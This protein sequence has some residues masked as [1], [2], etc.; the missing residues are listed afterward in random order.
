MLGEGR[1]PLGPVHVVGGYFHLASPVEWSDFS[2][3]SSGIKKDG[4]RRPEVVAAVTNGSLRSLGEA[5]PSLPRLQGG[6]G[7]SCVRAAAQGCA[8]LSRSDRPLGP[9]CCL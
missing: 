6:R 3:G 7:L 2:P 9:C 8:R 1:I 4:F 5:V